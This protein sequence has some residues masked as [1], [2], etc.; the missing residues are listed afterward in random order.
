[1]LPASAWFPLA[2]LL[3][4]GGT[5]CSATPT[6]AGANGRDAS[7]DAGAADAASD[8]TPA[9]ASDA[10]SPP[11]HYAVCPDA[12]APTFPSI[13]GV[14]LSTSS[15]GVGDRY[16]CHSSTGALPKA[17]GGTGSLL[18]FSPDAATVYAELLGDGGGYPATN[19]DGDAGGVVLRVAPGD[20][21]ASLLYIKL[22]LPTQSDPRYGLAM[23]PAGLVCPTALDAIKV[24]IDE[25]ALAR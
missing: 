8:A 6:S 13:F 22:T 20:A 9:D 14:M 21:S 23:P 2:T 24:W 5:A 4:A 15:C 10:T 25:G 11:P 16:D 19:V 17:E 3:C 1:M 7:V 18:D 12:M